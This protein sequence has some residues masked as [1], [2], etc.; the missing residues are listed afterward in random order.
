MDGQIHCYKITRRGNLINWLRKEGV[1]RS[2]LVVQTH[3]CHWGC[4]YGLSPDAP[5]LPLYLTRY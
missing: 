2:H 3:M 5:L 4:R 1:L